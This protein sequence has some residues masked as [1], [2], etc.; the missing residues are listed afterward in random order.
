MIQECSEWALAFSRRLWRHP[1]STINELFRS[2]SSTPPGDEKGPGTTSTESGHPPLPPE[3][4]PALSGPPNL[5][6]N[7][8]SDHFDQNMLKK[9]HELIL[10]AVAAV[11]LQT[12]LIVIAA[13]TAYHLNPGSSSL[14]EIKVYGFPCYAAG[15][16]LLS[17]GTGL[18]SFIVEHSTIEH[19]WEAVNSAG[20][21]PDGE[22]AKP[23]D[24]APRLVWIQRY[25][26]VNDQ[27]FKGYIILAGPKRRVITSRRDDD[28]EKHHPSDDSASGGSHSGRGGENEV[29]PLSCHHFAIDRTLCLTHSQGFWQWLTVGAALSAG[30]GFIAQFMGLRGLAFPCSIAQLGAIFIMALIRASIRRRLGRVPAHCPA[31]EGYELDF[32]ATQLVFYPEVRTSHR[33]RKGEENYRGD[34]LPSDFCRWKVRTTDPKQQDA[35]FVQSTPTSQAITS[36]PEQQHS[37]VTSESARQSSSTPSQKSRTGLDFETSSSQQLIRVRERLGDLCHFTS[38]STESALSLSQSIELF[39]NSFSPRSKGGDESEGPLS[40]VNWL[41]EATEL[42]STGVSERPDKVK[43][44]VVRRNLDGKWEVD[45]AKIDA[46]LSLWMASIEA[47]TAKDAKDAQQRRDA[48]RGLG[49]GRSATDLVQDSGDPSPDWRRIKVGDDLRRSF[50]RIIGDNLNDE[51]L[52]RDISWWVDSIIAEQSDP[53]MEDDNNRSDVSSDISSDDG[54]NAE[55]NGRLWSRA[56]TSDVDLVIGFNGNKPHDGKHPMSPC[57]EPAYTC[58]N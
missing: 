34:K 11:L 16:I 52:K 8:S 20:T 5:Q 27:S 41:I 48:R 7:L 28:I 57:L 51:V 58:Q 36:E 3:A 30:L 39:M 33:F 19:S 24:I 37:S 15:S 25:Q 42:T 29:C 12:G 21:K 31:L 2:A 17:I 1:L 22:E 54:S 47:K 49:K 23:E 56:R 6:L 43:I 9:R 35:F 10:A 50:G 4:E 45:V 55:G 46:I 13:A 53:A 44:P 26:T 38:E 14:F 32:L 18:C 40:Y